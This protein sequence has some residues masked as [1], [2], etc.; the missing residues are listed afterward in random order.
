MT[1]SRK[2]ITFPSLKAEVQQQQGIR[3]GH[4]VEERWI[5]IIYK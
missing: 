5:G 3:Q 1:N 4:R 2:G